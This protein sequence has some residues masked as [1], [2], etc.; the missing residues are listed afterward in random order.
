MNV[1]NFL[2][3]VWTLLLLALL[4]GC[5]PKPEAKSEKDKSDTLDSAA[6]NIAGLTEQ[7]RN[8]TANGDLYRAR[9]ELYLSIEKFN[10]AL[11][12]IS[13]ALKTDSTNTEYYV[14]LAD[15]FLAQG[16]VQP[17]LET[18]D[19]ALLLDSGNIPVLLK[20]AEINVVIRDYK[21]A[22]GYIDKVMK[23]D[24]RQPKAFFLRG[25][26]LLENKDTLHSIRNFQRAIDADQDYFDAY[27]Q[28][29]LIYAAARNNLA[30]DY[31]NNALNI[32]PDNTDVSYYL[33]MFYQETGECV[34][35]IGIYESLINK[36]PEFYYALY[37]IGYINLVYLKDFDKA[38]EC[39]TKVIEM[40]PA[41]TD[42]WYNRGFAYELKKDT[43]NSQKDYRKALE[44]SPNY[45][46]AIEG[47]NRIDEYVS[48]VK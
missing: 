6:I 48:K 8:D 42:A 7:I 18:M 1:I 21:K 43:E 38:I 46:K 16:K 12:D 37:N 24:D 45:E 10:E 15:I 33:A 44:L 9:A 28:L 39:F 3:I 34:K 36:N 14:T 30:V 26:V 17:A 5:S 22:L 11:N 23:Q 40:K 32:Q 4:A 29:G 41:Y 31:F 27:M 35:A 13:T 20:S 25:V 19:K 2:R 47:L